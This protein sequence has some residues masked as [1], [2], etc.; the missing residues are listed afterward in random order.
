[1][2]I[3]LAA[4]ALAGC[5]ST[6]PDAG[7][8]A[9]PNETAVEA[10]AENEQAALAASIENEAN[11][12]DENDSEDGPASY[13][14]DDGTTVTVDYGDDGSAR[15]TTGGKTLTMPGTPTASGSK[16]HVEQ[17]LVPGRTLSWWTKGDSAMLIQG[18]QGARDGKGE[19][20]VNCLATDPDQ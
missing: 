1:M 14:C 9:T 2:R 13:A 6:A 16:Y 5:H 20:I 19:T 15:L 10:A 11:V 8:A 12:D 7:N 17:G 3:L 18:P 4:L